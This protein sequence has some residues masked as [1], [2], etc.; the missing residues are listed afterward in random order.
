LV[1]RS[2][3]KWMSSLSVLSAGLFKCG[4]HGGLLPHARNLTLNCRAVGGL[5]ASLPLFLTSAKAPPISGA[6]PYWAIART[7]ASLKGEFAPLHRRQTAKVSRPVGF[8]SR[9]P[10]A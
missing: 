8:D 4:L 7:M 5:L 10:N 6:V 3:S 2:A 9:G 1:R